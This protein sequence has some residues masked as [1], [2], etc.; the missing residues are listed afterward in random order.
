MFYSAWRVHISRCKRHRSASICTGNL[1]HSVSSKCGTFVVLSVVLCFRQRSEKS[2]KTP[3]FTAPFFAQLWL[4]GR[5]LR[6]AF[7]LFCSAAPCTV[8][9][10]NRKRFEGRFMVQLN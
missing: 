6:E 4:Y 9:P 5:A 10:A 2:P 3:K 8:S 1:Q 7:L